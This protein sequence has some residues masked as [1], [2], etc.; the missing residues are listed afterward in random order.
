MTKIWK[1]V[2]VF[3]GIVFG[4]P[5]MIIFVGGYYNPMLLENLKDNSQHHEL[6]K[7]PEENVEE[8]IGILA[9]MIPYT[10][11]IENIKAN[12]VIARTH[13]MKQDAVA[14]EKLPQMTLK[15]MKETW[16]SA[17]DDIYTIYKEAVESTMGEKLFYE[18]ELIEA[19][20]HKNNVG[21]TRDGAWLYGVDIP[22][23][24]S[25]AS[26]EETITNQKMMLK[27]TFGEILCGA[28][29]EIV[30]TPEEIIRQIQVISKDETGYIK[31]LQIGNCVIDAEKFKTL[32][33]LQSTCF[34]LKS[35]GDTLIFETKGVGHG[36]GFSQDGAEAMAREG[37]T[38]QEI[39]KHYYTGVEIK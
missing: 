3:W 20:Y 35:S 13:K 30:L 7:K 11:H 17:F 9:Y 18:S 5:A 26:T 10:Q 2:V 37:A 31:Q 1:W 32:I 27:M 21:T 25:V 15:D 36:V 4:M 38:Y 14:I 22:Y 12:A 34:G 6:N 23:L 29:P 8:M 39:L 28:Y 24:K 33:G 16:G 19:V